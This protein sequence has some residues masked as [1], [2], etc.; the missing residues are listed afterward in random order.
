MP[1]PWGLCYDPVMPVTPAET[2]HLL[3][4]RTDA[5]A[6]R[7]AER[8]MALR[9]RLPQAAWLL[10]TQFGVRRILLFGSLAVGSVH[11]ASDVDLAVEGLDAP[12]YFDALAA[13]MA[14]FG[15]PVDLV[16]IEA[17]PAELRARVFGEGVAL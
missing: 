3:R 4:A 6:R 7:T 10:R 17:A 1:R 16:R 14:L 11:A 5:A 8:A 15:C 9:E 12:R 13:L 2:A